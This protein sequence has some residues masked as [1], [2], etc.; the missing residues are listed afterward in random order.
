MHQVMTHESITNFHLKNTDSSIFN[1]FN[2]RKNNYSFL[3]ITIFKSHHEYR[4]YITQRKKIKD[5][6]DNYN[7]I[8]LNLVI[9]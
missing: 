1:Y 3:L 5:K 8:N 2:S 4:I 7:V 9:A 6:S